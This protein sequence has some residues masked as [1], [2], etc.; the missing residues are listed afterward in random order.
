MAGFALESFVV[1]YGSQQA[2]PHTKALHQI[3]VEW[4]LS[5]ESTTGFGVPKPCLATERDTLPIPLAA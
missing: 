1:C 5:T 3:L 2:I 4:S